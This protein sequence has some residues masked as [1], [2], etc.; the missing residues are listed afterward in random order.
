MQV[1]LINIGLLSVPAAM[2][3]IKV[4]HCNTEAELDST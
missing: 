2:E 4:E 3:K 1:T